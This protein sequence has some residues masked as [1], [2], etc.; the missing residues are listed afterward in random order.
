MKETLEFLKRD[1]KV[2]DTFIEKLK[3]VGFNIYYGSYSYWSHEP[4]VEVGRDRVWLVTTEWSGDTS[5]CVYR[6]QNEVVKEIY[7][8]V[9]EQ[10]QLA[11][12]SDRL[13]DEFFEKLNR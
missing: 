1:R 9:K 3:A 7:G 5:Y 12:E 2:N 10:K 6:H 11:E 4:Y 13:V 8:K